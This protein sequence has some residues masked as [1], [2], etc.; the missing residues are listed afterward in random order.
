MGKETDWTANEGKNVSLEDMNKWVEEVE[1]ATLAARDAASASYGPNEMFKQCRVVED[2]YRYWWQGASWIP[3]SALGGAGAPPNCSFVTINAE[4]AL[5]AETQHK[6]IVGAD[7]HV[8]KDHH[9]EHESG[10]SQE[11]KLDDLKTPDDNVDLNV[12]ITKHG[13]T[14]KLPDDATKYLSGIGTYTAPPGGGAHDLGGAQ[15]NVDTLADVNAK[16]SDATLDNSAVACARTPPGHKARHQ[17]GGAD[18]ISVVGLSGLLADEQ[19][20]GKIKAVTVDDA[21]K[22]DGKVLAFQVASGKLEYVAAPVPGVHAATHQNGGGDEVSVAGLS[23]ELADNQ[24]PKTHKNTHKT[25]G[26]DAFAVADPLD[27]LAR[28]EVKLGG[29]SKGKRRG[30]NIT[31]TPSITWAISD[32]AGNEEV[33]IQATATQAGSYKLLPDYTIYE[34][35]GTYYAMDSDG[36]IDYSGAVAETVL[37]S[38]ITAVGANGFILIH[39]AIDFSDDD[40]VVTI[41]Q[42]GVAIRYLGGPP[43]DWGADGPYIQ[44]LVIDAN[45]REVRG[46]LFEG[47][48]ISEVRFDTSTGNDQIRF[49]Y[50]LRCNIRAENVANKRGIVFDGKY[51]NDNNI[52]Y[53]FFVGCYLYITGLGANY[54]M[55]THVQGNATIIHVINCILYSGVDGVYFALQD[56]TVQHLQISGGTAQFAGAGTTSTFLDQQDGDISMNVENVYFELGGTVNFTYVDL[57]AAGDWHISDIHDCE[58]RMQA[59]TTFNLINKTGGGCVRDSKLMYHDNRFNEPNWGDAT[60]NLGTTAEEANHFHV[61]LPRVPVPFVDGSVADDRGWDIDAGGEYARA[62][63]TIPNGAY[64][65]VRIQ[66][67]AMS[68]VNEADAMRLEIAMNSGYPNEAY[69]AE[70]ISV[71]DKP[72]DTTNF[73]ANDII[74]WVLTPSDDAD[75]GHLRAGDS[76]DIK[77]LHEA[78]GGDDCE[79]DARFRDVWI[80]YL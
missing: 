49:C 69:N 75:I 16:I 40:G 23:G 15:H 24:P 33:D 78:A 52:D 60:V 19:N 45:I 34:V 14:P 4:G 31:N 12:S 8:T 72:S 80:E 11:I 30:I 66:I 51:H 39:E 35:A 74:K 37:E 73:A 79:T 50:F 65:V 36:N 55:F 63:A 71:A 61:V 41:S 38:A 18:K 13:L 59:G 57:A 27:A 3:F 56:G 46:C 17:N 22:A 54:G 25:G 64:K 29:V 58:F 32:D 1:Y 67:H 43:M 7:L 5:S 48:D 6:N 9:A 2:G 62:Y 68:V 28:L 21:A 44:K 53:I 42:K 76:L 10:G 47:L 20:A 70:A 26:S 77:V